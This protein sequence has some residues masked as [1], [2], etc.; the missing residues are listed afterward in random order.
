M[1]NYTTNWSIH[2]ERSIKVAYSTLPKTK[3]TCVEIGCFEGQGTNIMTKL[4]CSHEESKLYCIDPWEDVYVTGKKE[5]TDIDHY[6]KDQYS[7]F[8]H[9][10]NNN[11]HVIPMR[12][13]SDNMIANLPNN[14]DF[15]YIDG[16]H[17]P[18]QVYKDGINMFP[19][20]TSGG[21]IVFDDY[22]WEHNGQSC[23]DG[24]DKFL[25]EYKDKI[26]V[27]SKDYQVIVRVK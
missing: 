20:M 18:L 12:G 27:I 9:N 2:I 7:R 19:K 22:T 6:F 25:N 14:I 3:M 8:L 21:I 26:E 4:L 23:G 5:Y 13:Y 1:S 24:I 17:S 16:D 10:T 11:T 15:V